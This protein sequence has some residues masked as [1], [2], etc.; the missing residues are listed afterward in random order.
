[1]RRSGA[2]S[3][4]LLIALILVAGPGFAFDTDGIEGSEQLFGIWANATVNGHFAKESKWVYF[5][6]VSLRTTQ[7]NGHDGYTVGAVINQDAIGY[8]IDDHHTVFLG[9][10]FQWT[11]PPYSR[12]PVVENG[13]WQQHLYTYPSDYG[14]LQVRQRL[15]Q[16][17][18]NISDELAVRYRLMLRF[19]HPLDGPWSVVGWDEFFASLNTVNWGPVAGFD[20]NRVFVGVGYKFDATYRTEVGYMNQYINRD[21]RNDL[22]VHAMSLNLYF[23]L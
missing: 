9:Y 11:H 6:T 17:T 20:Q 5:G 22:M 12:V 8:R 13:A 2:R 10:R 1:M 4:T 23:D 21:L 16:R 14:T 18:V 15:D 3:A 19:S 7:T